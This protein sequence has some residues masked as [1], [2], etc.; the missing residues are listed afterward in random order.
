MANSDKK[1]Q[2]KCNSKGRLSLSIVIRRHSQ[3]RIILALWEFV[4]TEFVIRTEC[5]NC[6]EWLVESAYK[7]LFVI[8]SI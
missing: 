6:S 2:Q 1:V 4:Q 3:R 5:Q 8:I 7:I